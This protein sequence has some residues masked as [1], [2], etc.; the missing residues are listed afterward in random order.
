[1]P[2]NALVVAVSS[3]HPASGSMPLP[4]R[5]TRDQLCGIRNQ[6]QGL[7]ITTK[8]V[9]EQ[10]W[11]EPWLADLTDTADRQIVY[12]AHKAVGDTHVNLS[13]DLTGLAGLAWRKQLIREAITVGGMTGVL[14]MCMGDGQET[15]VPPGGHDP[16]ALGYEW[17]MNNFSTIYQFM[18]DGEDLTPYIVWCP[19]Y[20]GVV[21][22]WQPFTRVN[23]F[24]RMAREVIGDG[25]L[26]LELAYG[27]MSWTGERNIWAEPDGQCVDVIL[28]EFPI[29]WGTP[30]TFG[31]DAVWQIVGRMVQPYLRPAEQPADDDPHPPYM[32]GGGTPRGPFYYVALEH[33]A[34]NWVRQHCDVALVNERRAY[35]KA[36]GCAYVG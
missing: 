21:P 16:G 33:S 2:S 25:A 6:F 30:P 11:F 28:S 8:Q 19:G 26:A 34:Y 24:V 20:D 22:A 15:N 14:L 18:Q 23:E 32:L 12:D 3:G 35:L 5:P 17:L 1:M 10:Y 36:L 29:D 9:G 4:P 7:L 27:Y 31:C 13:L